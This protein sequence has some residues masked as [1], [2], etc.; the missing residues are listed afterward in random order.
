[1]QLWTETMMNDSKNVANY[2]FVN[3]QCCELGY[4]LRLCGVPCG[5]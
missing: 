3:N 4:D 1:M 5:V 2:L